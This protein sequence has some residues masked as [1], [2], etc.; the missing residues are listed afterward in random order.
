MSFGYQRHPRTI[1]LDRTVDRALDARAQAEGITKGMLIRRYFREGLREPNPPAPPARQMPFITRNVYLDADLAGSLSSRASMEGVSE[2]ELM[3]R[4]IDEGLAAPPKPQAVT[5]LEEARFLRS[6]YAAYLREA[7][8]AARRFLEPAERVRKELVAQLE[9]L[10][11]CCPHERVLRLDGAIAVYGCPCSDIES[12]RHATIA[13]L[14][15]DCGTFEGSCLTTEPRYR[16]L[17]P[18]KARKVGYDEFAAA[19]SEFRVFDKD[20]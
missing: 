19:L 7:E 10:R 16:N 20:R 3:R 1:Y 6:S 18:S 8:E 17:R 2:A 9:A 12:R 14:C 15:A 4:F 11:T 13:L 5:R